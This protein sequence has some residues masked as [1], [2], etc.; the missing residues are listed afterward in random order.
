M[1]AFLKKLFGAKPAEVTAEAPYKVEA[2]TP[3]VTEVVNS[4]PVVKETAPTVSEAKAPAK[5]PA[6]K[7]PA[8]KAPAKAAKPATKAP[9]KKGPKK[10]K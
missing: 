8:A 7:K 10:A 2:T 5:K 1:F 9:A 4:Q 3:T 6:A